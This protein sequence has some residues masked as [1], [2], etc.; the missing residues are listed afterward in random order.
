MEEERKYD[1]VYA[2]EYYMKHRK[3]KGRKKKRKTSSKKKKTK[4]LTYNSMVKALEKGLNETGQKMAAVEKQ[5]LKNE[6]KELD[7]ALKKKWN[8]KIKELEEKLKNATDEEKENLKT[9]IAIMQVDY[10]TEKK[11][12]KDYFDAQYMNKLNALSNDKSMRA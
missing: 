1:P 5:K 2:H 7:K 6:K 12:V 8:D 11:I 9:Q 10:E 4:K 3:L